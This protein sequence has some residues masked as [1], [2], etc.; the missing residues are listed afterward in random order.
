MSLWRIAR[1]TLLTAP[2]TEANIAL[3]VDSKHVS[4]PPTAT[5]IQACAVAG[6]DIPRFCYHERLGVAGNCRMCL[7]QVNGGAKLV[8][9]CAAPV[10]KDMR[11]ETTTAAVKKAREGVME[12]LLANHPLDCPICDQG[13]ECDLQ[14]QA[15]AFGSDRSRLGHSIEKRA[16]A[17]KDF[18]PLI[19]TSMNRCIHCTRCVRFAN[20]IA[21]VDALGTTGRGSDMQIGTYVQKT[22]ASEL[23]GNIID[24]CPVGALTSRPYA[25]AA[26]P[27][28]LR[29]TESIDVM[30]AVG[31]AVRVDSRGQ[32]VMRVLP[33]LNEDVNEEWLADKGR[34]ACDGLR[35][36]RLMTPMLRRAGAFEPVAWDL[37][38]RLFADLLRKTLPERIEAVAGQ[39]ADVETLLLVKELLGRL[40]CTNLRFDTELDTT[41]HAPSIDLSAAYRCNT[42]L[43]Q[44]ETADAVL[45]V[46]C[47][48]KREAP[49]LNARLRK[50]FLSR[51]AAFALIASEPCSL[52]Y[53]YEYLGS[54]A[55]A[56]SS[57]HPFMLRLRQAKR[58]A[59]IVG[60]LAHPRYGAQ[61]QR[62]VAQ[63]ARSIPNLVQD[64][65]N[66]FNVLP[67]DASHTGAL[68]IGWTSLHARAPA[69]L[70][71]RAPASLDARTLASLDA[72]TLASLDARAPASLDARTLASLDARAPA[73]LDARTPAS[74]V[75]L[76]NADTLRPTSISP[77]AFVVYQGHHG[78]VGAEMAD[79]VLP[80][81][82]YTEKDATFVNLE[83][84]GQQTV[85]AVPPPGDART[86]WQ[87]VRAVA[88]VAGIRLP[89]DTLDD[90][91]DRMGEVAPS[92][93]AACHGRVH[94]T[95]LAAAAADELLLKGA[96]DACADG[97]P[98][99][100]AIS[101]YY[102]T[103]CISRASPTMAKCSLAFAP[104]PAATTENV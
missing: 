79:L 27:W 8:A 104:K 77:G 80:G 86:D 20:E 63:L 72:R 25:F 60:Q 85:A 93:S 92:L 65:W 26:R 52:T 71:A 33:R 48:P 70:D 1:R 37:A 84:R 39:F 22:L 24:L 98:Y 21:G 78:D 73:S 90:V 62:L 96:S 55:S 51:N 3:T 58:P 99:E 74:L 17:D 23:S 47:D 6:I 32:E 76:I 57:S 10:A 7:V 87:I 49:L 66:G 42:S 28:E 43:E 5:I 103:D 102:M 54:T 18:G 75:Y 44:L 94:P 38:L 19:K 101:D 88:E 40:G 67:L 81:A 69:S 61:T 12:F 2:Q 34:F 4:V 13:G 36:Q 68:D 35:L 9:S 41:A 95:V 53:Q 59:I 31:A 50:A 97:G 82:A 29:C 91:R 16:V 89:Y 100:A 64:R 45:L 15:M 46:A 56:L 83:G 30:D 14:D 11:V